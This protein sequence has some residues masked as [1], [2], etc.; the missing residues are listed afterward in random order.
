MSQAG[1]VD[2]VD[3]GCTLHPA[4]GGRDVDRRR[5]AGNGHRGGVGPA[6]GGPSALD[7]LQ[8]RR[9][10]C[11]GDRS[12]RWCSRA[13]TTRCPPR[14]ARAGCSR[15]RNGTWPPSSQDGVRA[16][17]IDVYRGVPVAGRVKTELAA[18]PGSCASG[19]GAWARR[20]LDGRRCASASGWSGR[21]T[22]RPA[23]TSVTASASSARSR[24]PWL[25]TL[26]D[27]PDGEPA[28]GRHPGH[29]GL[30]PARGA[31][32]GVRR[33]LA[34][35]IWP[36]AA[37]PARPG[38]RC[39]EMA[40][41]RSAG[42][43]VPRIGQAGRRLAAPGVRVDPGDAVPLPPTVTAFLSRQPGRRHGLAVPD[44][45]LDRDAADAAAVERRDRQRLRFSAGRGRSSARASDPGC[46]TSSPSTST[47]R[48]ISSRSCST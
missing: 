24:C 32:G 44:Q 4:T 40:D 34:S 5:R 45:P 35:P 29:R 12:T 43:D 37:R 28:R 2:N 6:G 9:A 26:R 33:E 25:R 30:R 41:S 14:T 21:P 47:G 23:S 10:R 46:R 1:D 16:F 22:G 17:L 13:R 39:D 31:G 3:P 15:S 48:A 42:R 11:A 7:R 8:R 36:T 19:S 27:V 20:A 38:R 18:S